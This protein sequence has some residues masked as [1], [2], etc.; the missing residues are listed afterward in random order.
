M[1]LNG[2]TI[3]LNGMDMHQIGQIKTEHPPGKFHCMLLPHAL[4]QLHSSRD[5]GSA[6]VEQ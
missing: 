5:K 2:A 3:V 1:D 6:L 4:A